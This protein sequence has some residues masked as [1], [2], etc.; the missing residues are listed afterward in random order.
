MLKMKFNYLLIL[1]VFLV[2]SCSK[3]STET[4]SSRPVPVLT[5][6]SPASGAAGTSVVLSGTNFSTT[7]A[8]NAVSFN[9]IEA[10]VTAASATKLTVTAPA[11]ASTGRIVL[12]TNGSALTSS[13][14][15]IF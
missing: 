9:G 13:S 7:V 12:I 6:F 3:D 4:E 15:F 8:S 5:G 1:L 2:C 10:V 11:G 14:P